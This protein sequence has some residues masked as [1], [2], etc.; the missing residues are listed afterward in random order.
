MELLTT[1][2]RQTLRML[3]L[4][5]TVANDEHSFNINLRGNA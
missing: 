5:A 2:L 1:Q 3:R 4:R